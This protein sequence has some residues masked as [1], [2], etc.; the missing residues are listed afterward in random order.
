MVPE[1]I[2]A[3]SVMGAYN[4]YSPLVVKRAAYEQMR[5]ILDGAKIDG[6]KR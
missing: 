1:A 6:A 4:P 3:V 5:K 2:E